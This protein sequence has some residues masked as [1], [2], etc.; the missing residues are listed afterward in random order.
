MPA[1]NRNHRSLALLVCGKTTGKT[2]TENGDY[3]DIYQ[4]FLQASLAA[5]QGDKPSSVTN[6][7]KPNHDPSSQPIWQFSLDPYDVVRKQEYPTKEKIDDYDGIILTGSAASAYENVEWVNKLVA[8]VKDLV[9]NRSH[10]K[11]IGEYNP[12]RRNWERGQG[13]G[14]ANPAGTMNSLDVQFN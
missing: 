14:A 5:V 2:L 8:F 6:V 12:V 13:Q 9:E 7:E 4:R 10:I 3:I 1:P 11:V